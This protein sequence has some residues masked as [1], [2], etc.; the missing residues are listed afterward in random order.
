MLAC[1]GPAQQCIK[2]GIYR[3]HINKY[4]GGTTIACM[5]GIRILIV[6]L[7]LRIGPVM[8]AVSDTLLRDAM[9]ACCLAKKL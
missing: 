5:T 1:S 8:H 3:D 4:L 9:L 7:C 6:D 2:I